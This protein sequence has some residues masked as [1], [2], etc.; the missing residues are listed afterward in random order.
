[1]SS[2]RVAIRMSLTFHKPEEVFI[3]ACDRSPPAE[4]ERPQA[5][6]G[7]GR[8]SGTAGAESPSGALE[9]R[10]NLQGQ[11]APFTQWTYQNS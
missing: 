6:P 3:G 1:M 2:R 10:A 11:K 5:A 4:T 8:P 7:V 9:E